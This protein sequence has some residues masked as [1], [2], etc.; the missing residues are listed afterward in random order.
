MNVIISMCVNEKEMPVITLGIVLL[1]TISGLGIK[2]LHARNL[3]NKSI[4]S[5]RMKRMKEEGIDCAICL[6]PLYFMD[7][8]S[9]LACSH[10]FHHTCIMKCEKNKCPLCRKTF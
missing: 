1:L 6:D 4:P 9:T 2:Y 5:H 3:K 7:K 10:I 8:V